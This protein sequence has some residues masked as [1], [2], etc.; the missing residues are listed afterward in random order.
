MDD[1]QTDDLPIAEGISGDTFLVAYRERCDGVSVMAYTYRRAPEQKT[2]GGSTVE[3]G[4]ALG[5]CLW[6]GCLRD[7]KWSGLIG[8]PNAKV[9]AMAQAW[10]KK[11]TE[12]K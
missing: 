4:I 11:S 2:R 10:V 1:N 7:G 9:L 12:T 8:R 3:G 6:T 5:E